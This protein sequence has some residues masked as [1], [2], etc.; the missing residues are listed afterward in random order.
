MSWTIHTSVADI[1][2]TRT[3][4]RLPSFSLALH[5]IHH[6]GHRFPNLELV[7]AVSP[8]SGTLRCTK[9]PNPI[10]LK[11]FLAENFLGYMQYGFPLWFLS[12]LQRARVRQ[13]PWDRRRRGESWLHY[14]MTQGD[15]GKRRYIQGWVLPINPF[16]CNLNGILRSRLPYT[17][18]TTQDIGLQ[19][20]N[21]S[22]QCLLSQG[23][24]GERCFGYRWKRY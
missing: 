8:V 11:S 6:S 3:V 17:P 20:W 19:I 18:T 2:L 9:L 4:R 10:K 21:S 12:R 13:R 5:A 1:T 16:L 23:R 22:Q 7:T 14:W 15:T 24:C